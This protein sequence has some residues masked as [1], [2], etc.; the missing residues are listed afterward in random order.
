MLNAI[1]L[2]QPRSDVPTGIKPPPTPPAPREDFETSVKPNVDWW[3]VGENNKKYDSTADM[4][5]NFKPGLE[6]TP[7]AYCWRQETKFD[8]KKAAL[9]GLKY[10]AMT[11]AGLGVGLYAFMVVGGAAF[12][13]FTL[14]MAGHASAPPPFLATVAAGAVLGAVIG[15]ATNPM[16][17]KADFNN[18]HIVYGK[19]APEQRDGAQHVNFYVNGEAEGKVD[20]EKYAQQAQPGPAPADKP[21]PWWQADGYVPIND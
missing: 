10:G 5:K 16:D 9:D 4:L 1:S 3:Y 7:A 2:V 8:I 21:T 20:I 6:A 12:E 11:G 14:G 17:K 13:I 15:A 18:G 19:L